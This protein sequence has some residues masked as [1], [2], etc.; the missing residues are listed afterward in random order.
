M[1]AAAAEEAGKQAGR[2]VDDVVP[3][4]R[5][6]TRQTIRL[7][8]SLCWR[9][10]AVLVLNGFWMVNGWTNGQEERELLWMGR[11]QLSLLMGVGM[12]GV[13]LSLSTYLPR[14]LVRA[15][16]NANRQ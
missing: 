6:R 16:P 13:L 4:A 7:A 10:L 5:G 2:Q 15:G 12:Y 3:R 1:A 8:G 14:H 11:S 9:L